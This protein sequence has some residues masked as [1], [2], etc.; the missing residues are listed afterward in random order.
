MALIQGYCERLSFPLTLLLIN[1]P[2]ESSAAHTG[3]R[4]APS[5]A[6][7]TYCRVEAAG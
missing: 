4:L 7:H 2:G 3:M 1:M 6:A 5:D